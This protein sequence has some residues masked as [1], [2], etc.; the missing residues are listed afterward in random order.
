MRLVL[1]I[2]IGALAAWKLWYDYE[3]PTPPRPNDSRWRY[4]EAGGPEYAWWW[5]PRPGG[6]WVKDRQGKITA[7]WMGV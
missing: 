3:S 2:V 6:I 7:G 1:V 4:A 5:M